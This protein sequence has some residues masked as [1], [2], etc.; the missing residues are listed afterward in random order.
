MLV[1]RGL[2]KKGAYKI[3]MAIFGLGLGIP[4]LDTRKRIDVS[5]RSNNVPILIFSSTTLK[6]IHSYHLE[7]S[8]DKDS[9]AETSLNKKPNLKTIEENRVIHEVMM[10]PIS[11]DIFKKKKQ[12]DT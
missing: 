11:A 4:P 2:G 3:P 1:T 12:Y 6:Q 10:P 5:N 7:H 8:I 9:V